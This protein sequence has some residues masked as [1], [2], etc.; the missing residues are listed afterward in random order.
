[1]SVR[2][3]Y[4]GTNGFYYEVMLENPKNYEGSHELH[5][6]RVWLYYS[7]QFDMLSFEDV[8]LLN[9]AEMYRVDKTES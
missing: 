9:D 3:G 1:M 7:D 6:N 8:Y 4:E 5:S 2:R